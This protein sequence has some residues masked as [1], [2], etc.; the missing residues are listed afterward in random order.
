MNQGVLTAEVIGDIAVVCLATRLLGSAARKLGQPAVIG[1]I[2][3]GILL[4]PSLLGRLPGNL[5]AHLF[6][7]TA[8]PYLSVLAQVAI[9]VFMFIV[10]YEFSLGLL[11][12]HGAAVPI[13]A[14]SA[15]AIPL[16][17]GSGTAA[18]SWRRFGSL[19]GP[20]T[21]EHL[22][23]IFMGIALSI[24]ALPVLAAIVRER[25]L[26]GT[27]VGTV[28]TGAAGAM[29]LTAWLVLAAALVTTQQGT[30]RSWQET[31]LLAIGFV[32][33]MLFVVRPVLK[34]LM[35]RPGSVL[36]NQVPVAFLLA[37]GSA[38]VTAEL[39]VHPIFGGF[40]AGLA[41]PRLNGAQ[42]AD[43][44]RSMNELGDFLLP[45]FFAVTGLSV[46]I[47]ALHGSDYV[48]L[49]IIIVVASAGKLGPA[50]AGSRLSGLRPQQSAGVAVLIN[51]RGLTELI[52]LNIGLTAQIISQSMFTILVLMA[53][54][55]T[56]ATAPLLA[57]I[58]HRRPR[59]REGT[60]GSA[61]QAAAAGQAA[62]PG[63]LAG[64]EAAEIAELQEGD[65]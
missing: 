23:V 62:R 1:W 17:L 46:N 22:F 2:V 7:A 29:D 58:D 50:Y 14:V 16:L 47:G 26:A 11:R 20:H 43:V 24:T 12:G 38:W 5:T 30:G 10:G 8:L 31:T 59:A 9:V 40:L 28:A 39:G 19:A 41:M 13:V 60:A 37:M 55:T 44:V 3:A 52:V 33:V 49:L 27:T 56:L 35:S 57:A 51:T 21:S 15:L 34:F 32:V 64:K 6:P 54:V 25:G 42:D 4:G 63:E 48:L 53:L 36:S 65:R 18:A 45:L 61:A